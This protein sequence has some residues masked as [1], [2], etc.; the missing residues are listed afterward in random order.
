MAKNVFAST[1]KEDAANFDHRE[2]EH[3]IKELV[4]CSRLNLRDDAPLKDT[5]KEAC[6]TFVVA[7]SLRAGGAAVRMQSYNTRT[8]FAFPAMIWEAARATSA[9]P[10]FFKSIVIDDVKYG[11]GGIG[12]NNPTEEAIAEAHNIWPN[13]PIGCL[14]SIGTGLED[15]I[16]FGDGKDA[17]KGLVRSLVWKGLPKVAFRVEVA[18]YCVDC[19]ASCETVHRRVAEH[20]DRLGVDGRYFR[21][22]VPQGMSK[23]GLE[24]WEKIGDMIALTK[25]YMTHGDVRNFKETIARF[26]LKPQLAR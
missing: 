18:E 12:Y 5:R 14:V 8:A 10:T 11:D 6:K 4:K 2:F 26:L 15:A 7:T 13:H 3:Q 20:P 1:L 24:E 17:R 19:V 25:N 23:I 16:Q 22:N 21:F 9:A